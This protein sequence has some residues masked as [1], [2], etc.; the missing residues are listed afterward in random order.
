MVSIELIT[1]F[2]HDVVV[3]LLDSQTCHRVR[4][5]STS[6]D[7]GPHRTNTLVRDVKHRVGEG[8]SFRRSSSFFFVV[9]LLLAKSVPAASVTLF[10]FS[11]PLNY[12]RDRCFQQISLCAMVP[13]WSP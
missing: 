9:A 2:F 4:L 8:L 10:S 12:V 11:A 13:L 6:G 1:V 3:E 7:G 5:K